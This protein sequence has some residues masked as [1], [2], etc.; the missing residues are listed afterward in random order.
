[1]P[2]TVERASF[3]SLPI[4]QA[5]WYSGARLPVRNQDRHRNS[6]ADLVEAVGE[7]RR[8]RIDF[9]RTSPSQNLY[10]SSSRFFCQ[11]ANCTRALAAAGPC[12]LRGRGSSSPLNS[13]KLRRQ[14]SQ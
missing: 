12:R 13:L 5:G 11:A 14:C 4:C 3:A 7:I 10:N 1:M 8:V 2:E 6:I 9:L